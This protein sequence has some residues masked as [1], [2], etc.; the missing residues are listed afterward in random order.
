MVMSSWPSARRSRE[1]PDAEGGADD[2]A[3]EQ[4]EG[5]REIDRAAPPIADRA[6]QGRG[7]DVAGDARHRDRR[8]DAEEDQQRRHQE[9][10]ADAEH[11]GDESDREPH[12]QNDEDVDRQV[13]DRKVD[14]HGRGSSVRGS[15]AA[16]NRRCRPLRKV[17]SSLDRIRGASPCDVT[18][19][20]FATEIGAADLRSIVARA[21]RTPR[22]NRPGARAGR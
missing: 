1:Q 19:D 2:A 21:C 13:R 22:A 14:L 11:A 15:N 18:F 3:G 17:D 6:G 12:A 9:A 8:R 7:G 5:E 16:R 10:A 20:E 4:H